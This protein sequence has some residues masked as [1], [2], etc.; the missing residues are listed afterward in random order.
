MAVTTFGPISPAFPS[1]EATRLDLAATSELIASSS[2]TRVGKMD[3]AKVGG[4]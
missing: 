1:R 3:G 4:L 2:L